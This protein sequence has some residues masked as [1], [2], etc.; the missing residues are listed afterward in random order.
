MA[1]SRAAEIPAPRRLGFWLCLALVVGNVVGTG[2]FLIPAALAPYGVNA[3]YGWLVTIAGG[4]CLAY[5]FA[6]LAAAMPEA[7]GPYGY[8]EAGLGAPPAFFVMWSYWIS[9][10]VTNAAVAIGAVS[11]LGAFI[12]GLSGPLAGPFAAIALVA[13]FTAVASR[14]ARVSG[15]VQLVTAVLKLVPLVAVILLAA[16]VL[17]GDG[18]APGGFAPAPVSGGGVAAAAAIALWA[19]LGFESATVPAGK[20]RD[21]ARTIPR[22]TLA[23]TLLV[24]LVYLL[25]S[26]AVFL[27]LPHEQAAQSNAPLADLFALNWSP[28]AGSLVAAFAAISALGALNGWVLLQAEVPFALARAGVFPAAFARVNRAGMPALGQAV[29]LV[30]T[31]GLIATNLSRGLAGLY[32]FMI[33]LATVATLVLY[34]CASLAALALLRRGILAGAGAGA[35]AAAGLLFSLWTLW[36]AGGEAVLWGAALVASGIPVYLLMSRNRRRGTTVHQP[37]CLTKE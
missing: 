26:S 31:G 34:L 14:G 17:G 37:S 19:M 13:A 35:A 8:I 22:A 29:G 7:N 18:E 2:I 32:A 30:L 1:E 24:G 16:A 3:V 11:Y 9:L 5:V 28:A 6:R 21:P 20:V 15:G 33:L 23:G 36:G 27:L 12:P 25:S 4:L 10:W